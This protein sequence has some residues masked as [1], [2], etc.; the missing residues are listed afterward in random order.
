MV[1]I[2]VKD[3]NVCLEIG[4]LH[5]TNQTKHNND[6]QYHLHEMKWNQSSNHKKSVNVM[7]VFNHCRCRSTYESLSSLHSQSYHYYLVLA[8]PYL[9][10]HI[11]Y[12]FFYVIS[13]II[14]SISDPIL[15]SVNVSEWDGYGWQGGMA[16]A[17]RRGE[18]MR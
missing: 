18:G 7:W 4:S 16:E 3:N 5:V 1:Y 14:I 9:L 15:W 17:K 13:L 2:Q 11:F 10:T 6:Q 12:T 8:E